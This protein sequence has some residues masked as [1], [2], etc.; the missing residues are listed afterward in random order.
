MHGTVSEL[1]R[2]PVK[3]MAGE[4]V[5]ALEVDWRGAAGDRTHAV[6]AR[7]RRLT[8]R[9]APGLLRW[10][11]SYGD[12][13]PEPSAPPLARLTAPD[14]A[15]FGWDDP[16]LAAILG[17]DLGKEV[18]L[19]RDVDGQQDLERS[20]LIT[21]TASHA[22]LEAELGTSIDPRRWRTNLHLDLRDAPAWAD[23]E[24]E[25]GTLELE[26]G[27]VLDLLHPCARCVIPTREPGTAV[28]W[29]ALLKHLHRH[30]ETRFGINAR[31]REPGRVTAGAAVTLHPPGY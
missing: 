24:W 8:A 22:A 1:W 18:V 7:D 10:A 26:G 23:L 9:Q 11:A 14:G 28:K 30:H 19:T 3:S 27:V 13:D 31:V 15:G 16:A 12:A 25:A 4:R 29:P 17:T 2:Y 21:T 6:F 20:L 5:P